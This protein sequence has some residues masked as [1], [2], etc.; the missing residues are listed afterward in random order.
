MTSISEKLKARVQELR[1]LAVPLE[2]DFGQIELEPQ[3]GSL[4]I[5]RIPDDRPMRIRKSTYQGYAQ[6]ELTDGGW[7]FRFEHFRSIEKDAPLGDK[8]RAELE[9]Q[10]AVA[11]SC[12]YGCNPS[13]ILNSAVVDLERQI[14]QYQA[15]IAQIKKKLADEEEKLLTVQT[16]LNKLRGTHD[17][18]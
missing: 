13:F 12:W 6:L 2:I 10:L 14:D 17:Q 16:K 11:V 15:S 9:R 18:S 7:R 3:T 5:V 1:M 8:S 4:C